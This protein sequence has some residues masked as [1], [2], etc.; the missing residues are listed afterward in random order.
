MPVA[1]PVI[2]TVWLVGVMVFDACVDGVDE[3]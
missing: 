1:P 3:A 2:R